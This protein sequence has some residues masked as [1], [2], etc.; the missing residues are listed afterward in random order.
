M[1]AGAVFPVPRE[2]VVSKAIGAAL[3]V[4]EVEG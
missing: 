2:S 4:C 3:L 1:S